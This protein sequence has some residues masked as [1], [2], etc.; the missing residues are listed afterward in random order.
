MA[1]LVYSI[2]GDASEAIK[3]IQEESHLA[4]LTD[5]IKDFLEKNKVET[6]QEKSGG[7]EAS[8]PKIE[9]QY[10]SDKK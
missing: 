5:K 4:G 6:P 10:K 1:S 2:N 8:K 7:K 9:K 3:K